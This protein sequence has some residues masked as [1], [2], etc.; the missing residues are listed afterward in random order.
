VKAYTGPGVV[1]FDGTTIS[2]TADEYGQPMD[3]L[4]V[5]VPILED[6][7]SETG[8]GISIELE[9]SSNSDINQQAEE[10]PL[11]IQDVP[12]KL[13]FWS[14]FKNWLSPLAQRV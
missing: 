8:E 10:A 9:N 2:Y 13:S 4:Q 5:H 1:S 11:E 6:G 14:R 7:A 12:A 3:P